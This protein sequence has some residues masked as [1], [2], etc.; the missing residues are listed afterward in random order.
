VGA[1]PGY[2]VGRERE[3]A[4]VDAFLTAVPDRLRAFLLEGEAGIGKTTVW[5]AAVRAAE[6][7]GFRALQARPRVS[8]GCPMQR[9]PILSVPLSMRSAR[10]FIADIGDTVIVDVLLARTLRMPS[11]RLTAAD[12]AWIHADGQPF[13]AAVAMG[14]YP[15]VLSLV[16]WA[17]N[18]RHQRVAAA[19]LAI[20]G[21]PV[22]S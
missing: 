8:Q 5:L 18:P 6:D 9:S 20:C 14:D 15:V 19:K 11:G 13:T 21:E 16:R 12:P 7:R 2:V 17:D 1:E 10:R 3:L 22:A 4:A